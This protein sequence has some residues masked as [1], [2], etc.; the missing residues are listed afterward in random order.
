MFSVL[1][2]GY[3][4]ILF[5]HGWFCPKSSNSSNWTK[6]SSFWK[7]WFDNSIY[8]QI[9]VCAE[10]AIKSVLSTKGQRRFGALLRWLYC[11]AQAIYDLFANHN[12][13]PSDTKLAKY[14]SYIQ[15][16]TPG[17]ILRSPTYLLNIRGSYLPRVEK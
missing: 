11:N 3:N 10:D 6:I 2:W 7:N 1:V 14:H 5:I 15:W 16:F 13:E 17:H 12:L 4:W 8:T 9:A